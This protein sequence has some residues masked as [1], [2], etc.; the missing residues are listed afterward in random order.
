MPEYLVLIYEDERDW[1]S[2][3]EED[4]SK[5]MVEHNAFAEKVTAGGG[6]IVS[7]NALHPT[8]QAT[9][10]RDGVRTAG[11]FAETAEQLGGYYLVEARDLDHGLEI[12]AL[13]PAGKGCVE[14]RPVLDFG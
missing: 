6:K 3:T 2:A 9:T 4:E 1:E 14:V 10:I 8:K 12:G 7:S 13:C 11:Q 5:A